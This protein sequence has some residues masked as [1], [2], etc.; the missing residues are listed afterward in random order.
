MTDYKDDNLI[1]GIPD[2]RVTQPVPTSAHGIGDPKDT[3]EYVLQRHEAK[4]A[5][6]HFDLRLGDPATGYG[7]SW[8]IRRFPKPGEKVLAVQ[9]PTHTIGYF[10]FAG[11]IE[12]GYGAGKV[13]KVERSK[14]EIIE[15][16]DNKIK[17][18]L[19][20]GS[21]PEEMNL[22]RT[23]G[24][25]WLLLNSTPRREKQPDVPTDKPKMKDQ[26]PYQIKYDDGSEI[27]QAKIDGGHTLFVMDP[28]KPIR[29][30]SYRVS[31]RDPTKFIE[32]S[33][34]IPAI[35]NQKSPK[36]LGRTILRGET[37]A[38]N[39]TTGEPL[40]GSAIAGMLNASVW[41]SRELQKEFGP[42]KASPF[43]VVMY[44][45]KSTKDMLYKEKLQILKEVAARVPGFE[46]PDMA[47]TAGQKQLM[48]QR[49]Y[50]GDH[51]QTKEG[52][53]LHDTL[54]PDK[55]KKIKF[56][57]NTDV[58]ILGFFGATGKYK[59]RAV[60]GFYY[61]HEDNPTKI[62]GKVGT[63]F[64][65]AMREDMYKNP[66]DY[67]GRV[68]KVEGTE[69]YDKEGNKKAIQKPAFKEFHIDKDYREDFENQAISPSKAEELLKALRRKLKKTRG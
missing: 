31:K 55:A 29:A 30:F 1:I 19:Y 38:R 49:I 17:F 25:Y 24:N 63:G 7:H 41:K 62:I 9:Q 21:G 67:I 35:F 68:A 6:L 3:F 48:L 15:S 4:R 18:G 10:D 58:I 59:N 51:H 11:K 34:K 54:S 2:K 64:D 42:L 26:K 39:E 44:K 28:G 43:N 50:D 8:A 61:A 27:M 16:S 13:S 36:E 20:R 23:N 32:H 45:G 47:E 69:V 65:D 37:W 52:V 14:T 57:H 60:G 66:Q 22:I 46:L 33:H 53:I 56:K 12:S 5:G 40:P